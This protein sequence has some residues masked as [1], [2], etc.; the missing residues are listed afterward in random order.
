MELKFWYA[1]YVEFL[2]EHCLDNTSIIYIAPGV[3]S[4]VLFF[5]IDVLSK[6]R[7]RRI[8]DE[9]LVESDG[10]ICWNVSIRGA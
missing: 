2:V 8:L 4:F 10:Q 6:L 1:C 9:F 7:S 5:V 3:A